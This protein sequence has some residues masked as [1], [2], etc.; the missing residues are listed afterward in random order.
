[1]FK[2]LF[3]RR[4]SDALETRSPERERATDKDTIGRVAETIDS[5]LAVL[6]T[7]QAGLMRR[8]EDNAA[9]AALAAGTEADEYVGRETSQAD[10][11]RSFEDETRRARDRLRIL[12]Q[13]VLNLRFL[14]AAFLTRFPDFHAKLAVKEPTAAAER[15]RGDAP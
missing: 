15:P 5:A 3:A 4:S 7:E 10:A 11:L 14:R 12:D 13:H 2:A 8:V 6:Q 9:M 1:M